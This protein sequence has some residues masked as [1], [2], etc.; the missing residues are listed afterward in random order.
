MHNII[1]PQSTHT[2]SLARD[3]PYNGYHGTS[4]IKHGLCACTVANPLAKARG[5]SLRTGAQLCSISNLKYNLRKCIFQFLTCYVLFSSY[6]YTVS[7]HWYLSDVILRQW[8][9]HGYGMHMYGAVTYY[10]VQEPEEAQR[11]RRICHI[12]PYPSGHLVLK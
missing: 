3:T 11:R 7:R 6:R 1:V 2:Q 8:C 5:L 4:E 12:S 9:C 10:Q